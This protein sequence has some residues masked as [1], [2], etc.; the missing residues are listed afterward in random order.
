LTTLSS[1]THSATATSIFHKYSINANISREKHVSQALFAE[2]FSEKHLAFWI[3]F[4][5][6]VVEFVKMKGEG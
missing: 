2:Y 4:G 3:F 1:S 6:I 5:R